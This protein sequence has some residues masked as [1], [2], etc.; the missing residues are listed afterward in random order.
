[1]TSFLKIAVDGTSASGKGTL[2]RRLAQQFHLSYLDTGALYR[3]VAK[4]ILDQG[5]NPDN[6]DDALKSAIFVRD[7]FSWEMLEDPAIRTDIV[8]DATSRSSQFPPLR[9]ALIEFQKNFASHPPHKPSQKPW[10]GTILDGRDIGTIICPRADVKFYCDASTET[11]AQRRTKELQEKGLNANLETVLQEMIE[12]DTRDQNRT[13]NPLKPAED[14]IILDTTSL[15][16]DEV[17]EKACD[18]IRSKIA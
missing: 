7:H 9:E 10:S 14:A 2:A 18:I 5:G 17:F 8:A 11:R 15:S 6:E 4:H 13:K 16:A 3:A 12:R 1:M